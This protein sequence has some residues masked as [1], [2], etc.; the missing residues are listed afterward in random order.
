MAASEGSSMHEAMKLLDD[1]AAKRLDAISFH[2]RFLTVWKN[3]RDGSVLWPGGVGQ[4]LEA[5]FYPVE[6]FDPDL[7][8]NASPDAFTLNETQFRLEIL[9]LHGKLQSLMSSPST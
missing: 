3:M 4:I 1:F 2:N 6:C 7:G 8:C 9:E 5:V